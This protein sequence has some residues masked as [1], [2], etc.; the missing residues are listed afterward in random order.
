MAY[1]P[2]TLD[3]ELLA[4]EIAAVGEVL[5]ATK[6]SQPAWRWFEYL[7]YTALV[8]HAEA[9]GEIPEGFE[10]FRPD[11]ASVREWIAGRGK[12]P[13]K[14]S[15]E[16]VRLLEAMAEAGSDIVQKLCEAYCAAKDGLALAGDAATLALN[17]A[18]I[19]ALLLAY[20][21]DI[22]FLGGVPVTAFAALLLRLGV[23]ESLC[24]CPK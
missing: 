2:I 16:L 5:A 15:D 6:P 10:V 19:K 18:S 22:L 3:L 8:Q 12:L 1:G 20:G 17:V 23:L 14:I 4:E 9:K 13:K 7:A 21:G 11:A 24:H